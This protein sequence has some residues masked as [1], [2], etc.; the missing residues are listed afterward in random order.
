MKSRH[1]IQSSGV[2]LAPSSSQ[3][4]VSGRRSFHRFVVVEQIC[5]NHPGPGRPSPQGARACPTSSTRGTCSAST[6]L[7]RGVQSPNPA[8]EGGRAAPTSC[9]LPPGTGDPGG[10]AGCGLG[11]S[12]A[13]QEAVPATSRLGMRCFARDGQGSRAHRPIMGTALPETL[14]LSWRWQPH[15][16]PQGSQSHHLPRAV[17]PVGPLASPVT[18]HAL[19]CSGQYSGRIIGDRACTPAPP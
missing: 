7:C 18:V 8:R 16:L 12:E 15:P 2:G 4:A 5:E 10:A 19:F 13:L 9:S 14:S 6:S 1:H 3:R 17:T 11:V